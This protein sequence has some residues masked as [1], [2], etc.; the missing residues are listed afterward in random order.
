MDMT[1]AAS[2]FSA[3]T[4]TTTTNNFLFVVIKNQAYLAVVQIFLFYDYLLL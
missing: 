3:A 1:M 4:L 2:Y